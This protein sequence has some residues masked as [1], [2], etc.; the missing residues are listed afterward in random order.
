VD[1]QLELLEELALLARGGEEHHWDPL[2]ARV[3]SETTQHLEPI[4]CGQFE[5]EQHHRWQGAVVEQAIGIGARTEEEVQRLGPIPY[6]RQAVGEVMLPQDMECQVYI[7]WII[8]HQQNINVV[9]S[10][11]VPLHRLR[12][13]GSRM[14]Q[15][16]STRRAWSKEEVKR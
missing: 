1:A 3:R 8:F 4:H 12:Q 16:P 9:F 14:V 5:I 7:I 6:D 11:A 10:Q 2:G 15:E 13:S